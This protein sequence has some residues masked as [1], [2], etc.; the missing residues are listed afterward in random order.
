MCYIWPLASKRTLS[1]TPEMEWHIE[2]GGQKGSQTNVKTWKRSEFEEQG[3]LSHEVVAAL[4]GQ[5]WERNP[6]AW[7]RMESFRWRQN[8]NPGYSPG[9]GRTRVHRRQGRGSRR[10]IKIGGVL[11]KRK[12]GLELMA[13]LGT[14]VL[15]KGLRP[16]WLPAA[17]VRH[18][19]DFSFASPWV[20]GCK[21]PRRGAGK[22]QDNA[23]LLRF[24]EWRGPDFHL[25]SFTSVKR[26]RHQKCL[27]VDLSVASF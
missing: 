15:S 6:P 19:G 21:E 24:G 5:G 25:C 8:K 17:T 3:N 9:R 20:C 12:V 26:N 14:A 7:V 2:S 11:S 18:M 1:Y 22:Q 10:K 23:R 4:T 16:Q 13:G 27:C